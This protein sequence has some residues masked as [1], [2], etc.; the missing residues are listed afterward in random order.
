[1]KKYFIC[2]FLLL[3]LCFF[4]SFFVC[5]I[6]LGD[7][8][9]LEHGIK[10]FLG[11]LKVSYGKKDYL[12]FTSFLSNDFEGLGDFKAALQDAFLKEHNV[13]LKFI[14]DNVLLSGDNISVNLHWLKRFVNNAGNIVKEEGRSEFI[15]R[16]AKEGLKLLII[17]DDNPFL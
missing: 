2:S 12:S 3:G 1:M 17:R 7:K 6:A 8:P 10:V 13:E 16:K 11:E 9:D 5:D 15:I 14:L 4:F